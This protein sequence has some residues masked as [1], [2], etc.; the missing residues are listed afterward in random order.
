MH[1]KL[2]KVFCDVAA[3]RSFSRGAKENEVSQ[4]AASQMVQQLGGAAGR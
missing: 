4:S 2:L 3:R 1:I